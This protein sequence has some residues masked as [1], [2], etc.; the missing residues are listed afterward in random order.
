MHVE[1]PLV[2]Y[3]LTDNF[4]INKANDWINRDEVLDTFDP[5]NFLISYII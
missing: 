2:S 1:M 4:S 3:K 5:V